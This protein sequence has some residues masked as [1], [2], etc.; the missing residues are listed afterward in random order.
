MA[1]LSEIFDNY[2]NEIT[3]F[4]LQDLFNLIDQIILRD[5]LIATGGA[6]LLSRN[7]TSNLDPWIRSGALWLPKTPIAPLPIAR[8]QL[9]FEY[10]HLSKS[11]RARVV[12]SIDRLA[13]AEQKWE[14]PG[15]PLGGQTHF[16]A[17]AMASDLENKV[18]LD[19]VSQFQR[20]ADK[21]E[22]NLLITNLGNRSLNLKLPPLAFSV[23]ER[24]DRIDQ[25][26]EATLEE[27]Y[28][29][30]RLRLDLRA[31]VE[32]LRDQ[33]TSDAEKIREV[34]KWTRAWSKLETGDFSHHFRLGF[35]IPT[36][37][38]KS[39]GLIISPD[40]TLPAF[41]AEIASS[42]AEFAINAWKE[43][44]P[45]PFLMRPV[46]QTFKQYFS[47]NQRQRYGVIRRVAG[48]QLETARRKELSRTRFGQT[49][50]G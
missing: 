8:E 14:L 43:A 16:Y 47:S 38:L 30:Q 40:G 37:V 42:A 29:F 25:I 50:L 33:E 49:R 5:K 27:R 11:E 21:V 17:K 19:L 12:R 45:K 1:A 6:R 36:A 3:A 28:R 35:R 18:M 4:Q 15:L 41:A 46:F 9:G 7:S 48:Q 13:S 10:T 39:L 23:L 44:G 34:Q 31:L 2:Q 20:S 24:V 32:L 22:E 26:P